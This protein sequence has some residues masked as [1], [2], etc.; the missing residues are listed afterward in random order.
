VPGASRTVCSNFL[1]KSFTKTVWL[2]ALTGIVAVC[3]MQR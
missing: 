1:P 2:R 3:Q